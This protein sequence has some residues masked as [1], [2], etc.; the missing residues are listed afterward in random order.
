L[1]L[2]NSS[3]ATGAAIANES[4]NST[5]LTITSIEVSY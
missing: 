4:S 5:L 2:M 1:G 3:E